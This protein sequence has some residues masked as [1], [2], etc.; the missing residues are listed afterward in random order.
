M[1]GMQ[2]YKWYKW[3]T[4][5]SDDDELDSDPSEDPGIE[6]ARSIDRF[7]AILVVL[8][9]VLLAAMIAIAATN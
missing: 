5:A 1:A 7:D 2:R 8:A 6:V 9:L 4:R 3:G